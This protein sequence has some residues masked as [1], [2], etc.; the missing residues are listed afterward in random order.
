MGKT[1]ETPMYSDTNYDQRIWSNSLSESFNKP[2][3]LLYEQIVNKPSDNSFGDDFANDDFKSNDFA[4]N[5]FS[6]IRKDKSIKEFGEAQRKAYEDEYKRDLSRIAVGTALKGASFAPIFNTPVSTGIGSAMDSAGDAIIEGKNLEDT[7]KDTSK[8]FLMGEALGAIPYAGKVVKNV[9][10][11]PFGSSISDSFEKI[12]DKISDTPIANTISSGINKASD[13]FTKGFSNKLAPVEANQ[14]TLYNFLRKDPDEELNNLLLSSLRKDGSGLS[15]FEN[16]TENTLFD[17][18]VNNNLKY[19]GKSVKL[20]SITT[21]EKENIFHEIDSHI[22]KSEKSKDIV[23]R[24][25]YNYETKKDYFYRIKY[26]KSGDGNHR[27]IS[28]YEVNENK[29]D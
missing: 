12:A 29:Y 15:S 6:R 14:P 1:S 27:I 18:I 4:N 7:L 26:D 23:T 21:K 19:R 28:K 25:L 8:G 2:N 3:S 10:K 17:E 24:R 13:F 16:K 5:D 11:T 20:S 22:S 9:E